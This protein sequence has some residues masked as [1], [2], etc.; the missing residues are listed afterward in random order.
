[1]FFNNYRYLG[2]KE[3]ILI[4]DTFNKLNNEKIYYSLCLKNTR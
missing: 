2:F 3:K 4:I 1:M